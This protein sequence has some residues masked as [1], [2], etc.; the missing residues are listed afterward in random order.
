[1]KKLHYPLALLLFIPVLTS[2]ELYCAWTISSVVDI[3]DGSGWGVPDRVDRYLDFDEEGG[4]LKIEFQNDYRFYMV[5]IENDTIYYTNDKS[6]QE[7]SMLKGYSFESDRMYISGHGLTLDGTYD[8]KLKVELDPNTL[9]KERYMEVFVG[10][11][12]DEERNIWGPRSVF[13]I[14]QK[15][16]AVE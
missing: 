8:K 10:H 7:R 1:M 12:Y 11:A 5:S 16:V 15:G 2:C 6:Y 3:F 13:A 14:R 4:Q 9:G